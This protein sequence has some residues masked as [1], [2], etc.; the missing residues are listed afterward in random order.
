MLGRCSGCSVP[1]RFKSCTGV[2]WQDTV[3]YHLAHSFGL[4]PWIGCL[5]IIILCNMTNCMFFY[6]AQ[7]DARISHWLLTGNLVGRCNQHGGLPR[8]VV[9]GCMLSPHDFHLPISSLYELMS[10][11]I[12][13][14]AL[15]A[16]SGWSGAVLVFPF[17]CT[18]CVKPA[19]EEVTL[20]PTIGGCVLTCL[21]FVLGGSLVFLR[22]CT[23]GSITIRSTGSV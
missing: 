20:W 7:G 2:V 4:W 21:G 17:S 9:N 13:G 10:L 11:L 1:L 18:P 14:K 3:V 5:T 15:G 23:L 22:V 6:P 16:R 19:K 12:K 8:I